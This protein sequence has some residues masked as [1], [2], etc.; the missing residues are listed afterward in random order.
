VGGREVPP[1]EANVFV[2][3]CRDD[4]VDLLREHLHPGVQWVQ[5]DSAGVD[6]WMQSGLVTR[7][8]LWS[9]A[10]GCFGPPV[11]EQAVALLLACCRGF[12]AQA[13]TSSWLRLEIEPLAGKVVGVAGMGAVGAEIVKRLL[14]F[15]VEIA[16]MSHRAVDVS[17]V[18]HAFRPDELDRF[19]RLSDHLIL[20]LPLTRKTE[21]L[22]GARE[23]DLIGPGGILVNVGRGPV[24]DTDALVLALSSGRLGRAGLDVTDPEPLPEDHSL[25][26]LDQA[27]ISSHSANSSRTMDA[28]LAELVWENVPRF[29]RGEALLGAIDLERGY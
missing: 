6:H 23:L 19:L 22:I 7:E 10:R 13:R 25:W 14:A 26:A 28:A 1:Q 29:R 4:R 20:T 17:G 16:V 9:S 15:E 12:V 2:W 5:L 27:L 3:S 11:A 18:S 8:Q 21:G 24:V